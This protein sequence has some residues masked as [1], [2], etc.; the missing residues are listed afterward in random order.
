VWYI[1]DWIIASSYPD[2]TA[3]SL[4]PWL[5]LNYD[6]IS[7][8]DFDYYQVYRRR[9]GEAAFLKYDTVEAITATTYIDYWA[10]HGEQYEYYMTWFAQVSGDQSQESGASQIV[11]AA[12]DA[13]EWVVIGND[14]AT[15]FMLPVVDE[16]HQPVIQ[17]ETFEPLG[18]NRKKIVRGNTLGEE[19][20]VECAWTPDERSAAKGYVKYITD[21]AGPHILKSPFGD[22]WLVEFSAPTK[23][24]RAV[25]AYTARLEWIEVDT[26]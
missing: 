17:Q 9:V 13:D 2:E 19:G 18:M 4:L 1:W 10:G 22:V 14:R 20:W 26:I 24:Y 3:T 6:A 5:E 8:S 11:T 25:G 21:F 12:I 23:R 7:D 15:I 16:Q